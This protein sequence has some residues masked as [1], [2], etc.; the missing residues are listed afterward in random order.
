MAGWM[1]Y[2]TPEEFLWKSLVFKENNTVPLMTNEAQLYGRGARK[3][4]SQ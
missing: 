2:L 1:P 4:Q 3:E